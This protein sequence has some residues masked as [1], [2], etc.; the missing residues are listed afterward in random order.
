MAVKTQAYYQQMTNQLQYVLSEI[1]GKRNY[2]INYLYYLIKQF[3]R[4][5]SDNQQNS[6]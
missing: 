3:S 6:H 5:F 4:K 1:S 2:L